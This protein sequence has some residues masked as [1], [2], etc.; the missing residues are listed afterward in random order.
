M[1]T[2][3]WIEHVLRE[4]LLDRTQFLALLSSSLDD[5][6][7]HVA[8]GAQL[9]RLGDEGQIAFLHTL[10][11]PLSENLIATVE[12]RLGCDL[13]ASYRAFLS[14]VSNGARLFN[15]ISLYGL[16]EQIDRDPA[17]PLGQPIS[18]DYG[19]S[20]EPVPG[21]GSGE[22]C[23]GGMVGWSSHGRL[24]LSPGGRVKLAHPDHGEVAVEWPSLPE[25]LTSEI[26]RL[27]GSHDRAGRPTV[28]WTEMM[29]PAG[30]VWETEAEGRA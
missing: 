2:R 17:H 27:S 11:P 30:R 28:S 21:L 26:A 12:A 29:H 22:L 16:V 24:I 4:G 14:Q 7:I 9:G 25:F 20:L 8:G 6:P 10:Y 15:V 18:I 23:I 13:P 19:N 5:E 1:I 3:G